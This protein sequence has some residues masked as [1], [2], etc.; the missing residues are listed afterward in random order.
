V[1]VGV[2]V[3]CAAGDR[4]VVARALVVER[5]VVPE[6]VVVFAAVFACGF[7]GVCACLL[8]VALARARA[9]DVG[10]V[11]VAG[12]FAADDLASLEPP[13]ALAASR[14]ADAARTAPTRAVVTDL[15]VSDPR[16]GEVNPYPFCPGICIC[17]RAHEIPSILYRR[18]ARER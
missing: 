13:Q 3:V 6:S 14:N 17:G 15:T 9:V 16:C 1:G 10:C 11:V 2:G 5:P 18:R 12:V 4:V 7:V 8:V